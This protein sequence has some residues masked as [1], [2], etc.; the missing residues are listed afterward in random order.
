M[1]VFRFLYGYKRVIV[2]GFVRSR[3]FFILQILYMN[4][5]EKI[6]KKTCRYFKCTNNKSLI[7]LKYEVVFLLTRKQIVTHALLQKWL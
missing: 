2:H 6:Q 7:I 5:Y 4:I 1:V 3:A